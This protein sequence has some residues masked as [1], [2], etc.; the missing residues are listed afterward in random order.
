MSYDI[1]LKDEITG[2]TIEFDTPHD[3]KGGTYA[4]GGTSEAWLNITYNYSDYYYDAAEGDKRFFGS[5]PD[6]R[7]N[8][9]PRNLGIRGIYGKTGAESIPMLKDM[10]QMIWD[11][12]HTHGEW[13]TTERNETIYLDKKG[14]EIDLVTAMHKGIEYTEK[15]I[16]KQVNEGPNRDYWEPTAG[17]AI[18]PLKQLIA[19]A[20]MR[21]DGVWDGD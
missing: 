12:Y 7:P 19:M 20:Q 11:K 5:L 6:D 9:E 2:E 10:V 4:V 13:I 8:E 14:H 16:V 1:Y 3:M 17:N 15:E 21:P 18:R